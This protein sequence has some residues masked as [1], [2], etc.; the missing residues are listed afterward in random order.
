MTR[1]NLVPVEDLCDQHL[2][3][4]HRELTRIP[5]CVVKGRYNIEGQPKEYTLGTGHVK[6]FYDKLG[7]L[8]KRY[9]LLDAECHRRGKPRQYI[10]PDEAENLGKFFWLDYEPT[11]EALKINKERII[12]RMPEHARYSSKAN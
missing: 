10:W 12:E 5:N 2:F 9:D 8:K 6:F 4:E 11:Q 7:F 3:A 1:I